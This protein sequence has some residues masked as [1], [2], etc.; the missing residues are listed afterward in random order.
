MLLFRKTLTPRLSPWATAFTSSIYRFLSAPTLRETPS[1]TSQFAVQYLIE[2]CGLPS[3]KASRASRYISHIKFPDKPDVVLR[4]L[5]QAGITEPHIRAAACRDPQFLC[6]HV[7]KCLKP[8]ISELEEIGFSPS[9]ISLLFSICPFAFKYTKLKQKVQFWMGIFGSF[10]KLLSAFKAGNYLLGV[11]LDNAVIPNIAFLK[12]QC[13][14]SARQISQLIKSSPRRITSK[15]EVFKMYV[16]RAKELGISPP[17]NTF[18]YALI[19]VGGVNQSSVDARLCHLKSLGLSHEEVTLL[20]TKWPQVLEITEKNIGQKMEFLLK[21]AGCGKTDVIQN[22]NLLTYSLEKRLI[23]RGLVRKLL[24][25]RGIP[26]ANNVFASFMRV[27]EKRFLEKYVLPY[28]GTVPG[29]NQAYIDAC[30]GKNAAT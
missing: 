18:V 3:D 6:L 20:I 26:A 15:P 30:A 16:K 21:Q 19:V 8:R 13:G 23:P 10:E 5:K 25:S 22:P 7:E 9:E 27:N 1:P 11:N 2:S 17:S 28:E 4:F 29:L 12:E 24:K 14:L